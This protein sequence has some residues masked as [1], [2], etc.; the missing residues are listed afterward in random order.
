[1]GVALHLSQIFS[2]MFPLFLVLSMKH[3]LYYPLLSRLHHTPPNVSDEVQTSE[4]KIWWP[5]LLIPFGYSRYTILRCITE[6]LP[7]GLH[8][9][10]NPKHLFDEL[11]KAARSPFSDLLRRC[12]LD[13]GVSWRIITI[14]P[15]YFHFY[16][17][18]HIL[19]KVGAELQR[20]WR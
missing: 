10:S 20:C 16:S 6:N 17:K 2:M 4:G 18:A 7:L 15:L 11:M 9:L 13:S 19:Q 12:C 14:P 3:L 8:V 1:M 5:F